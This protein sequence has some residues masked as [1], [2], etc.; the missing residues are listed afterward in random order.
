MYRNFAKVTQQDIVTYLHNCDWSLFSLP[1]H[2][3]D[4]YQSLLA[5]TDSPHG[6]IDHYAPEKTVFVDG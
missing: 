3:F 6:A 1:D 5:L 4:L 2:A